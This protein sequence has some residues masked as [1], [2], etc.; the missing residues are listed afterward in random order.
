VITREQ[1]GKSFCDRLTCLLAFVPEMDVQRNK[2]LHTVV[3]ARHI[4]GEDKVLLLIDGREL[5]LEFMGPPVWEGLPIHLTDIER[6]EV[7]RGPG[8][9]LYGANAFSAVVSITTRK[10]S[11][12]SYQGYVQ[13][14]EH[15]S[16]NLHLRLSHTWAD[17]NFQ[18]S[19]GRESSDSWEKAG[20]TEKTSIVF[21]FN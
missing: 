6:I 15:G 9:A 12:N 21:M 4:A 7:I 19:G 16:T 8:S 20:F 5:N 17:W 2:P 13:E 10:G 14:G 3:D 18:F 1:I 11:Q